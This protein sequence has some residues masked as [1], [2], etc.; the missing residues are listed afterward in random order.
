[1]RITHFALIQTKQYNSLDPWNKYVMNPRSDQI[2]TREAALKK[3]M[4]CLLP[5]LRRFARCL[6]KD[7]EKADDLVQDACERALNRLDQVTENTGIRSWLYRIVYTRWID[8]LRRQK[9][10]QAHLVLMTDENRRTAADGRAAVS[11]IHAAMDIRTAL[12]SLPEDHRAAMVLVVVEGYR[13]GE[14]ATILDLP[15]GTVAS[16]VARA[17][18][19]LTK[20]MT[21]REEPR[22]K[23]VAQTQGE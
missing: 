5:C 21:H 14:A 20:M 4:V 17:R 1:M 3:E 16:R 18:G 9:T 10:R 22:L 23:T 8:R 7:S 13:Y 12:N 6:S 19:M 11:R 2:R 15:V